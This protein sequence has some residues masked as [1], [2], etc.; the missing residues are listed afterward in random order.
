V[1][2]RPSS[3]EHDPPPRATGLSD[4]EIVQVARSIV[5]VDGV[6][7]LTMRR[8]SAALGVA[9]GATY[10][11]V[12]T[13]HDLLVLIG[14]D[15]FDEVVAARPPA[16][17]GWDEQLRAW[18][19]AAVDVLGSSPGMAQFLMTHSQDVPPLELNEGVHQIL[20]EAGLSDADANAIMSA[21]FFQVGAMTMSAEG[22]A[23]TDT[24]SLRG[25]TFTLQ[26][27]F[28][29]GLEVIL[30]GARHRLPAEVKG[31]RRRRR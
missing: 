28:I 5:A 10:H 20:R 7:G 2:P 15:L 17:L 14:K 27:I 13:K 18:M 24:L 16:S 4:T 12:R 19:L 30:D 29:D 1:P 8:L 21:L 6:N 23:V 25:M 26:G 11:H 9:L 31:A 3:A 22:L